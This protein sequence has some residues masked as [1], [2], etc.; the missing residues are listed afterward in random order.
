MLLGMDWSS[1]LL[2]DEDAT[3]VEDA[4]D[5]VLEEMLNLSGR[6]SRTRG[7]LDEIIF[8]VLAAR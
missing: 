8:D 1:D 4:A 3:R 2:A 5:E 6:N 7:T